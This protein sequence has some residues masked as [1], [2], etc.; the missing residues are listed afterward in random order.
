MGGLAGLIMLPA[1]PHPDRS[2][3]ARLLSALLIAVVLTGWLILSGSERKN[4]PGPAAP[5]A[6]QE[7]QPEGRETPH[8]AEAKHPGT[9]V[10]DNTQE[11]SGVLT[12]GQ[13][14]AVYEAIIDFI[15]ARI[16]TETDH[17]TVATGIYEDG[18][19][20]I[21]FT[22]RLDN[23]AIEFKVL[24]ERPAESHL[25]LKVADYNYSASVPIEPTGVL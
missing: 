15:Y 13:Y 17:A 6:E 2:K 18:N 20:T 16:S 5:P 4:A 7:N 22:L 14:Q 8:P 9:V 1:Q 24:V 11:L 10:I 23:P 12:A 21:S 19:G 25:V 3:K